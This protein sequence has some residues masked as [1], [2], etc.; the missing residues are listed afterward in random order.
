MNNYIN[1][2]KVTPPSLPDIIHRP[3]LTEL[4]SGNQDRQI[5][6]L[7]GQ[8]GTGKTTL[9]ASYVNTLAIHSSWA[10]LDNGD[11][12]PIN[13]YYTLAQSLQY[14]YPEI[15]FTSQFLYP[16]I[17]A[18]LRNNI[19]LFREWTHVLFATFHPPLLLV[20]DDLE[21]LNPD[22]ASLD[23]I[24]VLLTEAPP[25]LRFLLL[26][27]IEP[28]LDLQ[29]KNIRRLTY[30]LPQEQLAFTKD[31]IQQFFANICSVSLPLKTINHIYNLSEGWVGGVILLSEYLK[32]LPG[33]K[34]DDFD[35]AYH[36]GNFREEIFPYFG[37]EI[38]K[39]LPEAL[40][41]VLLELSIFDFIELDFAKEF[42]SVK[43]TGG[44]LA[45]I[46]KRNLFVKNYDSRGGPRGIRYHNLF[47]EFLQKQLRSRT[48][49]GERNVLYKR[50]GDLYA[51]QA[52]FD[53][54]VKF[55][56]KAGDYLQ[57]TSI[58]ERAGVHLIKMN[59]MAEL[60]TWLTLLP[61]TIV[62][63]NPWLL[64]Y[65][66]AGA[67]F[68]EPRDNLIR[69]HK[70]LTL[71]EQLGDSSGQLLTLSMLVESSF[72]AGEDLIPIALLIQKCELLLESITTDRYVFEK[73]V[74]LLQMGFIYSLRL[75]NARKGCWASHNAYVLLKQLAIPHLQIAALA[76]LFLS[77]QMMDNLPDAEITRQKADGLIKKYGHPELIAT[78]SISL[79]QYYT[80]KGDLEKAL[81][82]LQTA[83][84]YYE[85]LG[86]LNLY[87]PLLLQELM[88]SPH[89]GKFELAE[90]RGEQLLNFAS[91][92]NNT[93]LKGMTLLFLGASYYHKNDYQK[94]ADLIR[95]SMVIFNA[96]KTYS[97]THI[98]TARFFL[99]IINTHLC[100]YEIALTE[101]TESVIIMEQTVG[102]T[103]M[104]QIHFALALLYHK[105]KRTDL[106]VAHLRK[107][108]EL[109]ELTE[110]IHF[111]WVSRKDFTKACLLI[112]EWQVEKG[113]DFAECLLV[114]HLSES[115]VFGLDILKHHRDTT[116]REKVFSIRKKIH[117]SNLPHIRIQALGEF[118]VFK[119]HEPMKNEE[120][121]RK[122][123]K[124]MLKVIIARGARNIPRDF[125]IEDL[126]PE[127]SPDAGDKRF[128]VELHRLRKSLEPGMDKEFGSS[129]I[130]LTE[131]LVSLDEDLCEV[132]LEHFTLL[133]D[134]GNKDKKTG[135]PRK[136]AENFQKAVD[137][138]RDDFLAQDLYSPWA[139][140]RRTEFK[141]QYTE[142]LI[143]LGQIY[144]ERGTVSKA[145]ACYQKSIESESLLE[146]A[147]QRLIILYSARG[148][149][150]QALKVYA[151]LKQKL[152]TEIQ[153][154]P[155]LLSKKLYEKIINKSKDG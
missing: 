144:E 80:F 18:G 122:H 139:Q 94:A 43:G 120:W 118:V 130:H 112:L 49:R 72:F 123:A 151:K 91:N 133:I 132:D 85:E 107:A 5:T 47:R 114:S 52:D 60:K 41:N 46:V 138:Y 90:Q 105:T 51:K 142:A 7:T 34:L 77:Q 45:A 48:E 83:Q 84:Y 73:A 19:Q 140:Q 82:H 79:G 102:K 95:S 42:L 61:D 126:W 117:R 2:S 44:I 31:E 56:F 88:L 15:D 26:S 101:L 113:T 81:Q 147:Y 9:A 54:A 78:Y 121:Q 37:E 11:S 4:L 129:Y 53:N 59:R 86:L 106:M 149:T 99:G 134:Q 87:L 64:Y 58:I 98:V 153:S 152:Q 145:I 111:Q 68:T 35:L 69:L 28:P 93:L 12:D 66:S 70:A 74:L 116:V 137:M 20:L 23:F 150:N 76:N 155:E 97:L 128:K 119:V 65:R 16:T 124:T 40:Q 30:S 63:E 141:K 103:W 17:S 75:W 110:H 115:A 6:I 57:A 136:A 3:R 127:V 32:R 131:N 8:A 71:F 50:A 10:I 125:I 27:R 104:V 109:F 92:I 36:S 24:K 14:A 96:E 21:S 100:R 135:N 38:F 22:S 89:L 55:Y 67:R 1:I 33:E 39:S 62:Q 25:E 29:K 108:M 154:E 146:H 143:E 148:K 13:L